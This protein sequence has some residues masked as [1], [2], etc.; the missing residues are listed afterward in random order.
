MNFPMYYD[1]DVPVDQLD[2]VGPFASDAE[3]SVALEGDT[4]LR[5]E[6]ALTL[7][8]DVALALRVA[9]DWHCD[10]HVA[11]ELKQRSC[12]D[13]LAVALATAVR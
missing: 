3:R 8:F 11:H 9:E 13:E 4:L 1:E 12:P 6:W 10:L 2:E 5:Y 7:G